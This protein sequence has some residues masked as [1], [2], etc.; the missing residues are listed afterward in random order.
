MAIQ[1]CVSITQ[2]VPEIPFAREIEN[3]SLKKIGRL[4]F[5]SFWIQIE[6]SQRPVYIR[7][8]SSGVI[9]GDA[10][11]DAVRKITHRKI[12]LMFISCYPHGK[13]ISNGITVFGDEPAANA[14]VKPGPI[15]KKVTRPA[16]YNCS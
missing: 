16:I 8:R 6:P 4:V 7:L 9:T 12:N 13:D 15:E 10:P 3:R 1:P 2:I 5:I 11:T 14:A